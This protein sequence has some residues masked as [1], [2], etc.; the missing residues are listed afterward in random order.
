MLDGTNIFTLLKT[1]E[2]ILKSNNIEE[3]R[4]DAE[5]LLSSVLQIKRSNYL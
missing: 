5:V 3:A 1:A 2:Q 4:S